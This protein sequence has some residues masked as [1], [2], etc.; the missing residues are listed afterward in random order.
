[1]VTS[2]H[3]LNQLKRIENYQKN[4]WEN[5]VLFI[6]QCP[7]PTL[8]RHPE[9]GPLT[10]SC[11]P[12][13]FTMGVRIPLCQCTSKATSYLPHFLLTLC[14]LVNSNSFFRYLLRYHILHETWSDST[15]P[16]EAQDP[17]GTHDTL[18]FPSWDL[19][20]LTLLYNMTL[21]NRCFSVSPVG[22]EGREISLSIKFLWYIGLKI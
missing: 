13:S 7:F 1:M 4:I 16:R 21:G 5:P 22:R 20:I 12:F 18:C 15:L 2:H 11:C 3:S 14:C 19:Q 9:P 6:A 10:V 17:F 8:S